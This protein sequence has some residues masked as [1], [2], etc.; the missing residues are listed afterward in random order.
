MYANCNIINPKNRHIFTFIMLHPMQCDS[1]YFNDFLE[2]FERIHKAK[3]LYDSIKFIFPE[4]PIMDIDYPKDKQYNVKSWYNY[5]TCYDN[6]N[7]I[8]K[9]NVQDFERSSERIINIIYNEAFILNKFKSIYLVGV[10]QGGTLLFNILNKLPRSVGGV[11]CIKTIYMDKY[12]KLKN[13]KKTPLFIFC[14][15]RDTI[16]NYKFQKLCYEKLKKRKYNINYTVINDLDHYSISNY[17]HKFIIHNFINNLY[18]NK[19]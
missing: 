17:E 4:S 18:D 9:I 19:L 5:Y 13:N 10:S 15:A 1:N 14:G 11:Y 2:Y 12:I 16:Y 8:D 6:L 7:K 3:Y